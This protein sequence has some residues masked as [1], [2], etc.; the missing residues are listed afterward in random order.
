MDRF[1]GGGRLTVDLHLFY[2]DLAVV[3]VTQGR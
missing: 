2:F 1:L 3:L